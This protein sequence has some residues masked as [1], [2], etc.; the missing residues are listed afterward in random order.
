MTLFNKI[1]LI[2]SG[3]LL[4]LLATVMF[5][6]FKTANSFVQNQLLTDAQ[7]TANSLGLS[8]STAVE[9][10][11]VSMMETMINAIF[12]SGY[13]ED[14]I[15][16]DVDGKVLVNRHFDVVIKDVP[17]WFVHMLSLETPIAEAQVS[18]GWMPFGS[19]HVRSH[20]G[21]AYIQLWDTLINIGSWF[22]ALSAA[23]LIA[24]Y[25][26]LRLILSSLKDVQHQA[27]A[28]SNNNF[29]ILE[30]IPS[31]K[32]FRQMVL[33]MNG[34]V[35]KVKAI[36]DKEAETYQKYYELLY[37]DPVTKINNRRFFMLELQK[38]LQS[39]GGG[40]GHGALFMVSLNELEPLKE[41]LGYQKL[42]ILLASVAEVLNGAGC[43]HDESVI[44][45][46]NGPDFAVL[47]PESNL[48]QSKAAVE[49]II[50]ALQKVVESLHLDT[51]DCRVSIGVA[52]Y[53]HNDN[54]KTLLS[55]A[56]HALSRAKLSGPFKHSIYEENREE[57]L[58][59]GKEE[60]KKEIYDAMA[61]SRM[62]IAYQ[63]AKSIQE[64]DDSVLHHEF[65]M[66]FKDRGGEIHAA[67]FF[68]PV[69]INLHLIADLDRYVLEKAFESFAQD[70]RRAPIAINT[71]VDF[72]SDSNN[73]YWLEGQLKNLRPEAL[74][75]EIPNS[76]IIRN[77]TICQDFSNMI[78]GQKQFIGVDNF[79]G[80]QGEFKF[81]ETL[82]P[83]YLKIDKNYLI[84]DDESGAQSASIYDS[85]SVITTG[86][87]I[88]IVATAVENENQLAQL[89]TAG[90]RY[91][92]GR[93]VAGMEMLN[94]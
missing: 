12:D 13:Y 40:A 92:Q 7:N 73:A 38:Q 37:K 69:V 56:D 9:G 67:G 15:L 82:K 41:L 54:Q 70:P 11:D 46:L 62:L 24:L 49:E 93:F 27:E 76:S 31:T 10:S 32:E 2:L 60:W 88:Q 65:F 63:A 81:L 86:L 3:F 33:A 18:A 55:K 80:Q 16:K 17:N 74:S 43:H 25:A 42:D 78:R 23:A 75:F 71:S 29:I 6:N 39:D 68:M 94:G 26:I 84:S 19:I 20:S 5:L 1:A 91:A 8:L 36:F 83:H 50:S 28:V 30:D 35:Q 22:I 57:K 59:L 51:H 47:I 72:I 85:L 90:V 64:G 77:L 87:N 48:E 44:A 61:E 34:M 14:I 53:D 58:V 79:S 21:H 66:R 89:K 52:T 45:R 4:I